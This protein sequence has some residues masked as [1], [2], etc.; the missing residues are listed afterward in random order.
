MNN[1]NDCEEENY[2]DFFGEDD[3]DEEIEQMF[4]ALDVRVIDD[5]QDKYIENQ[6]KK[7]S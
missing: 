3:L 5:D 1:V 4:A 6:I 2:G 7:L